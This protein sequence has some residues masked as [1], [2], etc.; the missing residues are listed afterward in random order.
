LPSVDAGPPSIAAQEAAGEALVDKGFSGLV[1]RSSQSNAEIFR[2]PL[3]AA[4]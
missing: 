4:K 2:A 3:A 1:Q